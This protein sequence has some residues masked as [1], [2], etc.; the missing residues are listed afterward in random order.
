L[1]GLVVKQALLNAFEDPH[2]SSIYRATFGLV[3]FAC[4]HQGAN[5]VSLAALMGTIVKAFSTGTVNNQILT[6]LSR[7]SMVTEEMADRFRHQLERYRVVSFFEQKP[8][9]IGLGQKMVSNS[10]SRQ[11]VLI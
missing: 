10:I 11:N 3:F 6:D 2:Y 8:M 4:P 7:N 1:G 5:G 9:P